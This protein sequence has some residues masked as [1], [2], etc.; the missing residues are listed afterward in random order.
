MAVCS[1][2]VS[3]VDFVLCV[4]YNVLERDVL[5][6]YMSDLIRNYTA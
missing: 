3:R 5:G 1:G 2:T 4:G 6:Y